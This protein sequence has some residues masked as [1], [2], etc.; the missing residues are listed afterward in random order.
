MNWEPLSINSFPAWALL[1]DVTFNNVALSE[2][3]GKG[4]GITTSVE[5]ET[6]TDTVTPIKF[7]E[8]P[9][10]LVLS[11]EAVDEYAKVD[12]NFKALLEKMG[13]QS[14]RLDIMLYLLPHM[15]QAAA[16]TDAVSNHTRRCASTPW[17]EY[18]RFLPSGVPVPTLWSEEEKHLLNGTSLEESLQ[19]KLAT[20]DKE[21]NEFREKSSELPF[22]NSFLWE[23]PTACSLA[24]WV[25]ADAWYRS[26][27]LEL[28][29]SGASMVPALDM[30]NHST[31]PSAY[32]EENNAGGV[33]LLMRPTSKLSGGEEISISYGEAKSPAEMLF[34]Y[35]FIDQSSSIREM[36]LNLPMVEDDPLSMAKAH[37]FNGP[38]VVT[39]TATDGSV[40][41]TSPF[42][43]LM[44][45]N[46]E[47]GLEFRVLQDSEGNRQLR[48]FWLEADVTDQAHDVQSLVQ[49]HL[50]LPVFQ[51][52][53]VVTL[54]DAVATQ[55][56]HLESH[57]DLP[58][59]NNASSVRSSCRDASELLKRIERGVLA[60]AMET[61]DNEVS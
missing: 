58:N 47:D 22:W 31:N 24:H 29:R 8:I 57:L 53:V 50:L 19:A 13:R 38:R 27:C 25:L 33:D 17:T 36:V 43:L 9:Y 12:Q 2:V 11:S 59:E 51:L 61:L 39:L 10:D 34:S 48:M 52:R 28:P 37:I 1:Q 60:G 15:V 5:V 26:R 14:T 49:D 32:Y 20:L 23:S 21:F 56:G 18:L 41:W 4:I 46:E 30:V 45:L 35:G 3:A 6:N 44:C 16:A 40:T 42:A 54:H 55:L 7:L